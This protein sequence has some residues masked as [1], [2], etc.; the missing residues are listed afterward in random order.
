MSYSEHG[1]KRK[2][3]SVKNN[4][5]YIVLFALSISGC[6]LTRTLEEGQYLYKKT[7]VEIVTEDVENSSS[8]ENDLEEYTVP[9]TNRKF[10]KLFPVKLWFYNL[11]GDSVPDKGLRHRIRDK[12]GEPPV[13][14]KEYYI[15]S[16]KQ[17]LQK[18]LQNRGFFQPKI[19][20]EK[21]FNNKKI[22]V[23]YRVKTGKPY[24]I[25]EI[26]YPKPVDSLTIH[27]QTYKKKSLIKPKQPYNLDLLKEERQRIAG[28]LK[29]EG[30]FFFMPDHLIFHLDSNARQKAIHISLRVKKNIPAQARK[31]FRIGNI[32]VHHNYTMSKKQKLSDTITY[33]GKYYINYDDTFQIDK[34]LLNRSITLHQG[35]KYS[36]DEYQNTIGK[37]TSLGVFKFVNIQF[38]QT[39]TG[40]TS[41]LKTNIYLTPTVPKS[42]RFEL[43]AITKSNDYA[44]PGINVN[45]RDRN[46][47]NGAEFFLF[48]I[49]TNFETQIHGNNQG[50][51]SYEIGGEVRLDIPKL[52]TPFFDANKY[53]SKR[54]TP[55]TQLRA[56]Y[57][58]LNRKDMFTISDLNLS[59]GY[60]WNETKFKSHDINLVS[61]DLFQASKKKN[62]ITR[63]HLLNNRL[64]EQFIF[65]TGYSYTINNLLKKGRW[66]SFFRPSLEFAGLLFSLYDRTFNTG[67]DKSVQHTRLFGHDYSRYIRLHTDYR[68]Y[69]NV[70]VNNKLASRIIFGLGIPYG[71]SHVIPYKKQ[72]YVGGS[73]SLRAFPS[74]SVGPGS[75]IMP[76]SLQESIIPEQT[77]DIKIEMNMEYRFGIIQYLRGALFVD[78]GNIWLINKDA[79]TPGGAFRLS[80]FLKEFAIGTGAGLRFDA[81]FFVL[82]LDMAFPLRKPYRQSGDRWVMQQIDFF[83]PNWRKDNLILNIAIGYPF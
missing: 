83:N 66:K 42:V 56:G 38:E 17:E 36:A 5:I 11:A 30:F 21:E 35:E 48:N 49:E 47:F 55:K 4:I 50:I 60:R 24:T 52:I 26:Q 67:E 71:R 28:G 72:F 6:T 37:L 54:F 33:N 18:T 77:G 61:V 78:A 20:V 81:S 41:V 63:Y 80:S 46:I 23:T 8:L 76:D 64:E 40:D 15:S 79:Q 9:T 1:Q 39:A 2:K 16:S 32:F 27:M 12:L 62:I 13:I 44:G 57:S 74:R 43:Q 34:A 29:N 25:N 82:R 10:L 14:Y 31:I 69:Y 75:Y 59:Y 53:I 45:Y 51:N 3:T 68:L 65:S 7:R 73:N 58:H 19:E 22:K 70:D